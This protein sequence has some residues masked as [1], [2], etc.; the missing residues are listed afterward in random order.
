MSL[1]HQLLHND[2]VFELFHLLNILDEANFSELDQFDDVL[3]PNAF[4][5]SAIRI[6]NQNNI[7][8][9]Q[10][11]LKSAINWEIKLTNEKIL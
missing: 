6:L 2:V 5:N 9:L 11:I 7:E 1:F 10:K 3:I 8:S 4:V